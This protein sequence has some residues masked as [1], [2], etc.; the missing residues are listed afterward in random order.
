MD[1]VIFLL[2]IILVTSEVS[3]NEYINFA[4]KLILFDLY[5]V[6]LAFKVLCVYGF[7]VCIL[8]IYLHCSML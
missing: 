1:I 6:K 8:K 7:S 4:T 3:L 2:F 5:F